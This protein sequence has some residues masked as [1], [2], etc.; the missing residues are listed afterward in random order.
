MGGQS[1]AVDVK[2]CG[3]ICYKIG[4]SSL[5]EGQSHNLEFGSLTFLFMA[6]FISQSKNY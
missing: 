3:Q 5:V 6:F 2:S 1:D 4:M